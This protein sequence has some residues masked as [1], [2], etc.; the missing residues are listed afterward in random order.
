[1][2]TTGSVIDCFVFPGD[3]FVRV[4][5]PKSR[6]FVQYVHHPRQKP[7]NIAATMTC[8]EYLT[9]SRGVTFMQYKSLWLACVRFLH[10]FLLVPTKLASWSR[11]SCEERVRIDSEFNVNAMIGYHISA[12]VTFRTISSVHMYIIYPNCNFCTCEMSPLFVCLIKQY[13]KYF[14]LD[15]IKAYWTI[16]I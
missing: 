14:V 3:F 12:A 13:H 4:T 9:K 1:M 8:V 6:P 11:V 2:T 16:D 7:R 5:I 10:A 15:K